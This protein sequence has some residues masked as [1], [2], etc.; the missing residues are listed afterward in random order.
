LKK[1]VGGT[2]QVTQDDLQRGFESNFG[3]RVELLA[4]VLGNHRQAQKVWE[5]ARNNPTDQFFGELAHQYSIEPT[6]RAN[7]GK[8]PPIRKHGGQPLVEKEAFR[9]KAGELSGVVAIGDQYVILRCQGRTKPVV[10]EFNLVQD[11]L[12]KDL[13]EKKLR[14]AMAKEFDRLKESAQ[15]DNFLT[16]TSQLGARPSN[17]VAS[18]ASHVE[19]A[20]RPATPVRR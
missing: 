15:I 17:G 7:F 6:S 9:L 14:I 1:L 13:H 3:E 16:G 10:T 11:E 8:V 2:I 12:Q 19:P 4:I 5:M 18:Q 20:R